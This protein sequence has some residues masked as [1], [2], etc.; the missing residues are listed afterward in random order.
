L[1]NSTNIKIRNSKQNKIILDKILVNLHM[2]SVEAKQN[3]DVFYELLQQKLYS[4]FELFR[5]KEKFVMQ[6]LNPL[7]NW[8]EFATLFSDKGKNA[9]F[10]QSIKSISFFGLNKAILN[11]CGIELERTNS[12]ITFALNILSLMKKLIEEINDEKNES[13]ILTQPHEDRYLKDCWHNGNPNNT[14]E[15]NQ[16]SS[17][18]I[19]KN[20]SLSLTKKLTIFKKF[21][22]ILDGGSVLNQKISA[23]E[24]SLE[25]YLKL[26]NERRIDAV[27]LRGFS[28]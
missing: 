12:T 15:I 17:K 7:K 2:I 11:H 22:N 8:G 25:D 4:I 9:I 19:R 26:V 21:E 28:K 16:Y 10:K 24:L 1:L 6:K 20:S 14:Q 5:Y 18:I 3:D 27:S 13:Y 23:N